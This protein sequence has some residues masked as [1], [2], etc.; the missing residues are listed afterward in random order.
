M[1][2]RLKEFYD[3]ARDI[4]DFS[5]LKFY[6]AHLEEHIKLVVSH[7]IEAAYVIGKIK[8]IQCDVKDIAIA[9]LYHDTGMNGKY[10]GENDIERQYS[11]NDGTGIRKNHPLTSAIHVL[12]DRAKVEALGG[13]ADQIAAMVFLH[14]KSNSGVKTFWENGWHNIN[15]AFVKI[16]KEVNLYNQKH[17]NK[18]VFNPENISD[19]TK[20]KYNSAALRIGDACGH[21]ANSNLTQS[22]GKCIVNY[23]VP[24]YLPEKWLP[25]KY[26][27]EAKLADVTYISPDEKDEIKITDEIT[28]MFQS[29]EGNIAGMHV[30]INHYHESNED[31]LKF[32]V[33]VKN[34]SD[35]LLCTMQCIIERL[36]E[37][38][39]T[40]RL[41]N[42]VTI[43]N[44]NGRSDEKVENLYKSFSRE[45]YFAYGDIQIMREGKLC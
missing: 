28:K 33:D 41:F 45:N 4:A 14:S 1:L 31:E 38:K 6:K 22:G 8:G 36:K 27:E 13:N 3:E 21:N 7:S 20:F 12:E 32:V 10:R 30:E 18:I 39:G 42:H 15:E 24:K 35:A 9:S 40:N 23:D 5:N 25:E 2:D 26:L 16:Q 43:I 37:L 44:L 11:V 29:G 19:T 17:D 34:A